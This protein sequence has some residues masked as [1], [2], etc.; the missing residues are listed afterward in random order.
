MEVGVQNRMRM[1]MAA[2]L[3]ALSLT[4]GAE[5]VATGQPTG[6]AEAGDSRG[7]TVVTADALLLALGARPIRRRPSRRPRRR[8]RRPG[9]GPG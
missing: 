3:V 5:Q 9:L 4:G 1:V 7:N 2:G 6:L 8:P